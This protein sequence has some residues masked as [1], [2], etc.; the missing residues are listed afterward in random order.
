MTKKELEIR[1]QLAEKAINEA[2]NQLSK[3]NIDKYTNEN[4]Y[5]DHS[6][7]MACGYASACGSASF[8]LNNYKDKIKVIEEDGMVLIDHKIVF[9]N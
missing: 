2:L 9:F 7:N 3:D 1:L 5:K 4:T 6:L 8:Y